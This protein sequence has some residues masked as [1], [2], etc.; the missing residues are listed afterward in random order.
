MSSSFP[1]EAFTGYTSQTVAFSVTSHATINA[2]VVYPEK[3]DGSPAVVLLHYHGGFLIVGDRYTFLPYWLVHACASRGWVFVTPDYRLM[4]ESTAHDAIDDAAKVYQWVY[5]SLPEKLGRPIRSVLLAGS[6]AGAYLALNTA[7]SA[8]KKPDAL[9]LIYGMLNP[10]GARYTTPGMNI[11]GQP[12]VETG[13][14]LEAWPMSEA[15][16]G[17]KKPVSA[18]PITNPATDPRFALISALHIDALFPDYMTGVP[19]LARQIAAQGVTAIPTEHM[20]L[21]PL[22]F[23]NLAGLPP[24]MLLH[25]VDDTA[26]PLDCST[27]AA[28]KLKASGVN[29]LTEF[30]SEAQHGFD[31]RAGVVD[32]ETSNPDGVAAVESL[33]KAISFLEQS[34]AK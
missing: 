28:E 23:G 7:V 4:P 27:A 31:A 21:F 30:P 34:V 24:V 10:S 20:R 26:V 15:G 32:I 29:I 13:P 17:E 22:D 8:V 19:G 3:S 5:S 1:L 12:L 16:S 18:Y 6:S 14:I 11:M 33:R 25:G 9:L 2:D